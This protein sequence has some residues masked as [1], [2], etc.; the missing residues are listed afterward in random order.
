MN[1]GFAITGSFCTFDQILGEMQNLKNK[2]HNILPV[3]SYS[4]SNTDTRFGT[5]EGFKKSVIEITDN[6][7]IVTLQQAEPVGPN[8]LIDVLVIA[9]CTGNTLSKLANAITDT[10]VTMVAKAHLRNNK[11]VVIGISTND[12]LG[13]NLKNI[14][15]LLNAKNIYFVPFRQDDPIKK[16]KS[17][18]SDYSLI[19][20]TINE[21]FNHKQIQPLLLPPEEKK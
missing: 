15:T 6:S 2:G 9:P 1:V 13:Q 10:P 18:I 11:P 4:V 19:E 16:P 7:P 3:F 17:M 5:A 12:A 14:A 8:N 20:A 21:A